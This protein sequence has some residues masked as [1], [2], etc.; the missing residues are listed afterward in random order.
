MNE[1]INTIA[2]TISETGSLSFLESG[3][4]WGFFGAA[5]CAL[6]AFIGSA[7][8]VNIAGEAAAGLVT[9]DPSMFGKIVIIENLPATQAIYGLLIAFVACGKLG[10]FSAEL[11][12]ITLLQGA[13]LFL[14]CLPMGIVGLFSA[15]FQGRTAA[16]TISILTK[17]PNETSK[18]ILI[19]AMV[20][21]FAIF[22]LLI[23]FLL[24]N[25]II[26]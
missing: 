25:F 5:L 4:F 3:L 16:A 17:N 2:T 26:K 6:L 12:D 22:A 7:R 11:A 8:G 18:C 23:S 19:T 24:V 15:I 21:T 13:F 10:L 1:A 9:E 20:E 14:A